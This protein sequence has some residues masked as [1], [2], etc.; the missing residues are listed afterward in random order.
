VKNQLLAF[1]YAELDSELA[2]V[3]LEL[4]GCRSTITVFAEMRQLRTEIL[5]ALTD[6]QC[7]KWDRTSAGLKRITRSKKILALQAQWDHLSVEEKVISD[8]YSLKDDLLYTIKQKRHTQKPTLVH[9]EPLT[10]Y[11][12]LRANVERRMGITD[13][14]KRQRSADNGKILRTLRKV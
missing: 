6:E 2:R 5:K 4:S 1:T 8:L 14:V 11:E 3:E 13:K 9:S 12:R 7:A 10:G